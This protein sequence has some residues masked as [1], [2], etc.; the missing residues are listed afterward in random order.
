[1]G[2]VFE[3]FRDIPH[4]RLV[5]N[6]KKKSPLNFYTMELLHDFYRQLMNKG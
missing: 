4:N 2:C 5:L 6:I 1:M 3:L